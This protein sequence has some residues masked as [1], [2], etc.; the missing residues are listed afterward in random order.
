[1]NKKPPQILDISKGIEMEFNALR[2]EVLK[3]IEL[4]E[5]I[6]QI[7]L[8]LAGVFLG[9]GLA[10]PA[11]AFIYP[12]L[13]IFLAAGW[14]QNDLRIRQI[15]SYIRNNL[16]TSLPGLGWESHRKAIEEQSRLG[17]L[18]FVLLSHGGIFALTQIMAIGIGL[19]KFTF[20]LAE[21][22][23]LGIDV[24]AL[25]LT[26]ILFEYVRRAS[27]RIDFRPENTNPKRRKS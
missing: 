12:T 14:A 4:R 11:I 1:M 20:T 17:L 2:E 23:L 22:V 5:Q 8:G 7:T 18:N 24:F 19:Y 3:R 27:Y 9:V 25:F 6:T 13:S 10:N 21:Q 16:E 15:G 26:F